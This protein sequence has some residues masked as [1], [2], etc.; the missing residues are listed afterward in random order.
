MQPL[1]ARDLCSYQA[2]PVY[3]ERDM[4]NVFSRS[5]EFFKEGE[6]SVLAL[7]LD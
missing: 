1:A 2:M 7:F 5:R 3:K 4:G 6:K